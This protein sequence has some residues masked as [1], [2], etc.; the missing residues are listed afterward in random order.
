[1]LIKPQNF[2]FH[3]GEMWIMFLCLQVIS[4]LCFSTFHLYEKYSLEK[5]LVWVAVRRIMPLTS[6]SP[7]AEMLYVF[8]FININNFHM[9][10]I[11]L[12]CMWS[13][14]AYVKYLTF[15]LYLPFYIM[16][17]SWKNETFKMDFAYEFLENS[18]NINQTGSTY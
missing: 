16:Y 3:L 1:M 5:D 10:W 8:I 15:F 6:L 13:S 4:I 18:D 9:Q 17:F 11:P 14:M 2:R 12:K 7:V